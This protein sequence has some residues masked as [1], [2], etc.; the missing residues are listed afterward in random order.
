MKSEVD[1]G[2]IACFTTNAGEEFE[3]ATLDE[4]MSKEGDTKASALL[5][6]RAR[7][8]AK[9]KLEILNMVSNT[10]ISGRLVQEEKFVIRI[11]S[12]QL[13]SIR[14]LCTTIIIS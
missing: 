9:A 12:I 13:Q 4:T 5:F 2:A 3:E 6:E 10:R 14:L 11:E 1:V 7:Q 8:I